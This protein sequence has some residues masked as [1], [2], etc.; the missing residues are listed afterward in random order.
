MVKP[1]SNVVRQWAVSMEAAR[2]LL[3]SVSTQLSTTL[4]SDDR[5][6][7]APPVLRMLL[8]QVKLWETK[9]A[10]EQPENPLKKENLLTSLQT[11]H[12]TS[13]LYGKRDDLSEDEKKKY[14]ELHALITGRLS[15]MLGLLIGLNDTANEG[16]R[17]YMRTLDSTIQHGP[18]TPEQVLQRNEL[19][20]NLS[21][22]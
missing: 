20:T 17:S 22:T 6:K 15:S 1:E 12:D 19:I 21:A 16:A 4:N 9:E 18:L 8:D 13:A 7:D 3:D 5:I 11:L 10:A 14:R 2:D